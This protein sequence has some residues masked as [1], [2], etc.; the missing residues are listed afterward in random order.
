[1]S[2]GPPIPPALNKPDL[3]APANLPLPALDSPR[4]LPSWFRVLLCGE[5]H[6]HSQAFRAAS[7]GC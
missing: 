4:P 3:K 5:V 2:L 6:P 7:L 1:M